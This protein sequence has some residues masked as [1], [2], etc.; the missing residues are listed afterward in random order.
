ML[1]LNWFAIEQGCFSYVLDDLS[2]VFTG[3]TVLVRG[4]GRTDFQVGVCPH[5]CLLIILCQ[6]VFIAQGGSSE[7]LYNSVH[8]KVF[9]LPDKC[10][11]YPAHDYKGFTASSVW[12][13]GIVI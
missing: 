1:W 13:G 12:E 7:Q 9:R 11:I 8:S 6:Y 4:C 10:I 3:D 5:V 2:A